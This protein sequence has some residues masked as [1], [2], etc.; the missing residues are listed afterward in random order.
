MSEKLKRSTSTL[1]SFLA[2]AVAFS[3]GILTVFAY[4][5]SESDWGIFSAF[6]GLFISLTV[7]SVAVVLFSACAFIRRERRAT[8]SLLVS[9]PSLCFALWAGFSYGDYAYERDHKAK[10]SELSQS[11]R[12][13]LLSIPRVKI[14][15][16]AKSLQDRGPDEISPLFRDSRFGN[17]FDVTRMGNDT[18]DVFP[19]I[20]DW[21]GSHVGLERCMGFRGLRD[22]PF[23]FGRCS[24]RT[25][26]ISPCT[27]RSGSNRDSYTNH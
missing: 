11:Y 2:L 3:C 19:A 23:V 8:A 15:L 6:R 12:E 13:R 10:E 5:R 17:A 22:S 25:R 16:N 9:I 24:F 21:I 20:S 7:G 1:F 26:G 27:F 4:E 18:R 14:D